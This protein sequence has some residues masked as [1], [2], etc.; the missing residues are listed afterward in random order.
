MARLQ[1]GGEA[2]IYILLVEDAS[3]D[4]YSFYIAARSTGLNLRIHAVGDGQE[5]IAFLQGNGPNAERRENAR[6]DVIV[7]DLRMPV[8]NG[9]DFLAWR[10]LSPI[11]RVVPVVAMSGSLDK[12][13]EEKALAF[14]AERFLEK[15][16]ELQ[17]WKAIV[18]EAWGLARLSQLARSTG[19][20][21]RSALARR[22]IR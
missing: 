22:A 8:I 6:P 13:W 3:S 10:Q 2:P 19:G 7:L 5:A 16:S 11:F 14:G 18:Q 20:I 12:A 21:I 9:F 1:P 17:N 4:Q 15:T